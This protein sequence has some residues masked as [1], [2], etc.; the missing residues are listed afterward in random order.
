MCE[1]EHIHLDGIST[2]ATDRYRRPKAS[3]EMGNVVNGLRS[4]IGIVTL[5]G[6]GMSTTWQVCSFSKSRSAFFSMRSSSS[7][8]ESEKS[9]FRSL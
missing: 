6:S 5:P 9:K 8:S 7:A 4:K 3:R 1:V 2:E